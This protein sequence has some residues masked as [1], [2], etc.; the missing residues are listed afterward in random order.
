MAANHALLFG[1]LAAPVALGMLFVAAP[2]RY[3]LPMSV[4]W[5]FCVNM[6]AFGPTLLTSLLNPPKYE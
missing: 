3:Q 5:P 4:N 2:P 1:A 6:A